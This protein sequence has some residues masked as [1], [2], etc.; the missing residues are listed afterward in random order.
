MAETPT[1]W[2]VVPDFPTREV[3]YE[4]RRYENGSVARLTFNRPERLNAVTRIGMEEVCAALYDCSTDEDVGVVVLTGSGEKAFC[5]GGDVEWEAAGGLKTHLSAPASINGALLDCSKPSIAAVKG[6][7]IGAGNHWAYYCDLTVAA[8]NAVFGQ[9]G[10]RIGSPADG[11]LS[12]YLTRVVGAKKAKEIWFL[13]H[14][15]TAQ[16]ALAMGLVN[17]VVPVAQLDAEVEKWCLEILDM[18]PSILKMLKASFSHD[19]EYMRGTQGR[20]QRL[21]APQWFDSDEIKE[22]QKSWFEKRKPRFGQFR[23]RRQS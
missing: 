19:I 1:P 22:A 18:S 20:F 9:N 23:Q 21:I 10:P 11:L 2:K 7:A 17:R 12:S 13:C 5:A 15:Y 6:Y 8:D 16:E 4:K 14:Q 3:V